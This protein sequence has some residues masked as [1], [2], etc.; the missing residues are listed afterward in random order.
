MATPD[1]PPRGLPAPS[2]IPLRLAAWEEALYPHPD[3]QFCR[4]ILR[5]LQQGFHVGFHQVCSPLKSARRNIS[6]AYEHPE[7]VD[8][9][10]LAECTAGRVLGP[11]SYPPPGLHT[12]RFGVIPKKSQPGK[13]RLI[14]DLSSPRGFSVNDGISEDLCSLRYPSFDLATQLVVSQGPGALLSKLDIKEPYRMV[15]VHQED[16]LLL[17]MQWRG[18]S[19]IDTRLPFGLRSAP[20]IF[21]A[22]ADALQWVMAHQGLRCFLHYLDDFL[23]VEPPNS[24][25]AAIQRALAIWE[26]LGVPSA[27]NKAEGPSTSIVFLGIELDTISLTAR[28]PADKLAR[29]QLLVQEWGDKKTC[30]KRELLSLIGVLQHA[31]SVVRFGRCFLR[32]MMDLS[33]SVPELHY[34]IRLNREFRSDLQW[35]ATFAP[36]WNGTCML[37]PLLQESP[38]IIVHSDA[39]G[40]QGFGAYSP[41]GWFQGK[42]PARWSS[43]NITAKELL[44][45]VLAAGMW[46][47]A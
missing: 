30:S 41:N 23:F 7:V 5:G 8:N 35:W 11:F 19:Y 12:R 38:H 33:T 15:P 10:L 44:P 37:T 45:I 27:P 6:S 22:V 13:W 36:Q 24:T 14:V 18:A 17:G 28:L 16:W 1:R 26:A 9:Y 43:T 47:R 46:G 25:G 21:T 40:A 2:P 3:K 29:L 20:K 39:S 31:A 4:Y 32:R 34:H 42:W